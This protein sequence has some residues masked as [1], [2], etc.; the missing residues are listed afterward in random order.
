M[1][2]QISLSP[3][4]RS[5]STAHTVLSTPPDVAMAALDEPTIRF[6]SGTFLSTNRAG[7][8]SWESDDEIG[9]CPL[10]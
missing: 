2:K 6:I 8:K 3:N 1:K 4:A 10:E 5:A 7:S 9:L